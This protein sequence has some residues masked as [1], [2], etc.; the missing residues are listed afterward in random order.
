M[1]F[2]LILLASCGRST[3]SWHATDITGSL[4]ELSFSLTRASDGAAVHARDYRGKVVV[5]YFGYTHCPDICPATLANLADAI[6]KLGG[7][8]D[9]VRVL[10]VTVDP[11]RDTAPLLAGY[12]RAFAPQIDG[13]RGSDDQ[14]TD[15]AR[16]YRV[17]YSVSPDSPGHPHEIMHSTAA[18]FFNRNGRTRLV[19]TKTG[20]VAGLA[21]DL[22][23][24]LD[25]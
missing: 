21:Q 18:F 2:L 15:I 22:K 19:A 1:A 23:R 5:L 3:E 17:V 10:F 14:L 13:L 7:R 25:M 24:L 11:A 20:D 6:K 16:R 9:E 12:V 4:P 8:A